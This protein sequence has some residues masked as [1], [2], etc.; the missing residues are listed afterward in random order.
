MRIYTIIIIRQCVFY[1]LPK[2]SSDVLRGIGTIAFAI[3]KDTDL[4]I[5]KP[6]ITLNDLAKSIDEIRSKLSVTQG[7]STGT[8]LVFIGIAIGI[9]LLVIFIFSKIKDNRTSIDILRGGLDSFNKELKEIKK[10]IS[11]ISMNTT[12]LD[13]IK[14]FITLFFKDD[15]I[16]L[17]NI[18]SPITLNEKGL[19]LSKDIESQKII[20]RNYLQFKQKACNDENINAYNIQQNCLEFSKNI[21]KNKEYFQDNEYENMEKI[22]FENGTTVESFHIIFGILLRDKI[23]QEKNFSYKDI[24][25]HN[26]NNDANNS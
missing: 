10:N 21:V 1:I 18:N 26:P 6:E 19:S 11:D 20:D 13:F 8:V 17:T 2:L 24:D 4:F 14:K 25:V 5:M 12:N 9:V 23:L 22:A 3:A 16:D 7:W 15:G